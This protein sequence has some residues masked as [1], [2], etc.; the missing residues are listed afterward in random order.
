MYECAVKF[1]LYFY[2]SIFFGK[3]QQHPDEWV[4]L[5]TQKSKQHKDER[6]K[7]TFTENGVQKIK[8]GR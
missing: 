8:M 7:Y 4:C 6:D 5:N 3:Y 1:S 2:T